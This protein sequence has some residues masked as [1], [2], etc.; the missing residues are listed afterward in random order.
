MPRQ[1]G[2]DIAVEVE[3]SAFEPGIGAELDEL[4]EGFGMHADVDAEGSGGSS[5]ADVPEFAVGGVRLHI[6]GDAQLPAG[7]LHALAEHGAAQQG[8]AE[9]NH[10]LAR[11]NV[12][13]E[14]LE[15]GAGGLWGFFCI[16]RLI[17]GCFGKFRLRLFSRL[18]ARG[19]H[20]GDDGGEDE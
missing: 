19:G 11:G 9:Q 14:V 16:R 12:L 15:H 4:G 10:G 8:V 3:F 17:G 2:E 20:A 18:F 6:E 5:G 7:E 1:E 13:D